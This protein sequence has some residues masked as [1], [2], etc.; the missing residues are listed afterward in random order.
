MQ[1]EGPTPPITCTLVKRA[2]ASCSFGEDEIH[3]KGLCEE[4]LG[5]MVAIYT[6][7]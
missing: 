7:Y 3:L 5:H 4:V 6:V 2:N 1:L